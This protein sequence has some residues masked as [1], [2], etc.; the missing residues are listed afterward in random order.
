MSNIVVVGG[1]GGI[2]YELVNRLLKDGDHQ[3]YSFSRKEPEH[4]VDG[5][6]YVQ[7]DAVKEDFPKDRL[8]DHVH[9]LAYAVGTINLRPFNRLKAEDFEHDWNVNVMGAIKAIQACHKGMKKAKQ[10]SIVLFSTVAAQT[11]MPFHASIGTAKSAVEGLTRSLAAEYATSK[12]RCNAV[13][14][15]LVDTPL[16]SHLLDS[17]EK[18]QSSDKRHPMGRVGRP[19]DI[20]AMA[21]FLLS[22]DS[23]WI[24]GQ[25]MHVDGGML[26]LK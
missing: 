17:D 25:V 6:Q 9:G 22:E 11:G 15:G 5:V 21:A 18:R 10:G 8:P 1:T 14:P 26:N 16:A 24:T 20:A 7:W 12:I 2:G 13:A 19:G 23:A 4:P 3:I